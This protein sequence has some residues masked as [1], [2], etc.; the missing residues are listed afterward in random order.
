LKEIPV[1]PKE[2]CKNIKVTSPY[3]FRFDLEPD[4][5]DPVRVRS[6]SETVNA[7]ISEAKASSSGPKLNLDSSY[8]YDCISIP[9][10]SGPGRTVA[11]LISV[12]Q[13]A[14]MK[15]TDWDTPKLNALLNEQN[16]LGHQLSM[17]RKALAKVQEK[18]EQQEIAPLIGE[19]QSEQQSNN[20][21]LSLPFL[22]QLNI[23]RFGTI[24]LVVIALGIIAPLYRFSA[25][26]A[27]FYRSR[28][29]ILSLHQISGYKRIGIDQLSPIFT[30]T[31]DF[32]KSQA[33][34]DNLTELI[35][36]TLA[37]GKDSE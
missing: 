14:E 10:P 27:A 18:I 1:I 8:D 29:D 28:A 11:K 16:N 12:Q 3:K 5:E 33:M 31:F 35:R 26:L 37:H 7:L 19:Q 20:P 30:P 23:T 17:Y 15:L 34:P 4:V 6:K 13:L 32:G 21:T 22:L 24:T 9:V 2:N 36:A 25:R